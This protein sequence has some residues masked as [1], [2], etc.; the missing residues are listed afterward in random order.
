MVMCTFSGLA[1][2]QIP[3]L[4]KKKEKTQH[5]QHFN[6]VAYYDYWPVQLIFQRIRNSWGGLLWAG[7]PQ[8]GTPSRPHTISPAEPLPMPSKKL[9]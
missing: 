6:V 1:S 8:G 9:T 4:K 5:H 2:N 3:M 7:F